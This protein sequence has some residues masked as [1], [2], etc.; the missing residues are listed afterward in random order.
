[1]QRKQLKNLRKNTGEIQKMSE[2]RKEKKE[3]LGEKNCQGNLQQE[4]YLVGQIK[5][6]IRNTRKGWKEIGDDGKEK[7]QGD[8]EQ[9]KQ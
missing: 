8:K 4:S 9:Q 2:D 3:Y 6:T 7:E 1:M 5:D